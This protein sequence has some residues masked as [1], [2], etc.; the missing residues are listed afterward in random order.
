MMQVS[1]I[2]DD[3][4]GEGIEVQIGDVKIGGENGATFIPTVS[5]NGVL[6]WE[7]DKQLPNPDPVNL[8]ALVV[9]SLEPTLSKK[10]DKIETTGQYNAYIVTSDGKQ[11][12]R[13]MSST[14]VGENAIMM[15]NSAGNCS[16]VDP[17]YDD[18]IT[19]KRYVD[20]AISKALSKFVNVSEGWQTITFNVLDLSETMETALHTATKGMTWREWVNSDYENPF[21][22]RIENEKLVGGR[23]SDIYYIEQIEEDY[24][25]DVFVNPDDEII[26]NILYTIDA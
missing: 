1:V 20:N 9:V 10:L 19:N 14:A 4:Y 12:Y 11:S 26:E 2:M 15:R 18:H 3:I 17:K 13:K 6:S 16:I 22:I 23:N 7:N 25:R 24:S 8:V 21:K 5:S